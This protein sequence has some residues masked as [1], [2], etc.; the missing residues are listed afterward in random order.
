LTKLCQRAAELVKHNEITVLSAKSIMFHWKRFHLQPLLYSAEGN[1]FAPRLGRPLELSDDDSSK[2]A[3]LIKQRLRQNGLRFP[4]L[5]S[6]SGIA[7]E[8]TGRSFSRSTISRFCARHG[9]VYV[10]PA[11]KSKGTRYHDS[12]LVI[13]ERI[14]FLKLKIWYLA[15]EQAGSVEYFVHDESHIAEK[16]SG[17]Q[18]WSFLPDSGK[19]AINPGKKIGGRRLAFSALYS[20]NHGLETGVATNSLI[21]LGKNIKVFKESLDDLDNYSIPDFLG[22]ARKAGILNTGSMSVDSKERLVL[23]DDKN[24]SFFRFFCATPS[25]NKGISRQMDSEKFLWSMEKMMRQA[26]NSCR[27]AKCIIFQVDNA[28]YHREPISRE[29]RNIKYPYPVKERST[30]L[31]RTS[32]LDKLK[33]WNI[34]PVGYDDTFFQVIPPAPRKKKVMTADESALREHQLNEIKSHHAKIKE[35]FLQCP[36]YR[37]Q[38]TR[39]EAV[40]EKIGLEKDIEVKVIFGPRGHSELAEIEFSWSFIKRTVISCNPNTAKQ[41]VKL[42]DLSRRLDFGNRTSWRHLVLVNMY[43]YMTYGYYDNSLR[44]KMLKQKADI[45]SFWDS[46]F[47]SILSTFDFTSESYLKFENWILK[48]IVRQ[49]PYKELI[50]DK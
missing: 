47:D 31:Y 37:Y 45:I 24:C 28:T 25:Q 2:L 7:E 3:K 8:I 4:T 23:P 14:T 48:K 9:F 19:G 15:W 17:Y 27:K 6:F 13:K 29:L 12:D 42:L 18:C 41:T 36:N 40:A 5:S 11:D 46:L 38:K 44:R 26:V 21:S 43:C 20:L 35:T 22:A 10:P 16:P 33:T 34:I 49:L 1:V 39:I 30:G 32:M 50:S